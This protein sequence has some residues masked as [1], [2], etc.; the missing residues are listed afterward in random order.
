MID[1]TAQTANLPFVSRQA[2]V[3]EVPPLVAGPYH[4]HLFDAANSQLADYAFTPSADSEPHPDQPTIGLISQIVNYVPGTRRIAIYSDVAGREIA[5]RAVSA[6]APEVAITLRS[7]GP[8]LSASG[9]VSLG[10]IGGDTDGEPLDYTVLYS[11]DNQATWRALATNIV[12]NSLTIDASQLE[13]TN[14]VAT[15]Y[16]RVVANDGVLT[17]VADSGPFSV[18]GQ[19]PSARIANPADGGLFS[20]GQ[21]VALEGVAQDFEDGTLGDSSLRWRSSLDGDLGAGRLIHPSL[22]SVGTHLI[23]LA[24]TDSHGQ[25][26]ETTITVNIA[27]AVNQ[28]GPT[29]HVGPSSLLFVGEAGAANPGAQMLSIRNLGTATLNWRA[30]SD[31][32]WLIPGSSSGAAPA[33]LSVAV[34]TSGFLSGTMHVAHITIT[35]DEEPANS[36][37]I[38]T[39]T[40]HMLGEPREVL[41]LPAVLRGQ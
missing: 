35:G 15:G 5:S 29:L 31:A 6:N 10:W 26:G 41:F 17:G 1:F 37:Q 25:T 13:G 20:Y 30:S 8:S 9:P 14:G 18:A 3:G 2:Q 24:A 22:L 39:V 12:S 19:A 21:V 33:E 40:V 23:T 11:F 16:F 34:N 27:A 36:P 7:G 4:I 38:I 28:P 32:T